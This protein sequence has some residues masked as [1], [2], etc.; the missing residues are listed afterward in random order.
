[1]S[2]ELDVAVIN[3]LGLHARPAAM[4]VRKVMGFKSEVHLEK[5]LPMAQMKTKFWKR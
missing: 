4:L 1:L 2:K 5:A 3:K